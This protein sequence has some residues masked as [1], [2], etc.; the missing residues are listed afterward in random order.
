MMESKINIFSGSEEMNLFLTN[1]FISLGKNSIE[2]RDRFCVALSG[3]S[4]P[5]GFYRELAGK[6]ASFPWDK[7]H[8]FIVDERFVHVTDPANNF[9]MIRKTLLDLVPIPKENIHTVDTDLKNAG[10]SAASYDLTLS[11]FFQTKPP[12]T[13]PVFDLILL[14]IGK[15]GHTASLFPGTAALEENS[16]NAVMVKPVNAPYERI[17]LTFPVLN[18]A[19]NVVFLATGKEKREVV[20]RILSGKELDLPAARV[21]LT[22][23]EL[24]FILDQE[25]AKKSVTP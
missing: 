24:L 7:T 17:S 10:E 4:T 16:R 21:R 8:I 22:H 18:A 3:G 1:Y 9:S 19:K 20:A 5:E 2:E 6:S 11:R 13:F 14:G 15:D 25:A 23:G 12:E